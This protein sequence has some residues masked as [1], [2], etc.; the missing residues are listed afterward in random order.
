MVA[1][2]QVNNKL[3]DG[4]QMRALK[5]TFT[6]RQVFT[7]HK[8]GLFV[9]AN[10]GI[11]SVKE[12]DQSIQSGAY[13][14]VNVNNWWRTGEYGFYPK[15]FEKKAIPLGAELIYVEGGISRI[16]EIPDV[17]IKVNGK[18]I[19]LRQAIG[20]GVIPL[21][22]LEIRDVDETRSVVSVTSDFNPT[23]D[24]EVVDIMRPRAWGLVDA[25]GRPLKSKPSNENVPDA[26]YSY[27]RHDNEFDE[28]STGW[29][30]SFARDVYDRRVVF[31][32]SVW[33]DD[34]GV[35]LVG[36]EATA[37]LVETEI[38]QKL[39]I[40]RTLLPNQ[41]NEVIY[42]FADALADR[43]GE[44]SLSP[45]GFVNAVKLLLLDF[46][47]G[48]DGYTGKPIS[49]LLASYPFTFE[50][51]YILHTKEIAHAVCR[52]E[53]AQQVEL[54]VRKDIEVMMTVKH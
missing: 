32:N 15:G 44:S 39:R 12:H 7:L 10:E 1:T 18:T 25:K 47:R 27:V 35:A 48:I 22:K 42:P 46:S 50:T 13:P 21:E 52:P 37:P 31:A 20:M 9:P 8:S 30:G 24:V 45:K 54:L 49:N 28:G 2:V 16:L 14:S 34:S 36:R 29:H 53:F 19:G 6:Q 26:R 3:P 11:M 51:F 38:A 40:L 33:S 17:P 41:R 43:L 23:T 5:G 4:R